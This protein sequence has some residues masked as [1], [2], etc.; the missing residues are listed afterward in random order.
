M[1]LTEV[2]SYNL[3]SQQIL[4]ESWDMLTESQR[5]HVGAWEKNVWPLMEQLNK[6][7]EA[8]LTADQIQQIFANAEKVSIEGGKN[9]TALGK[10]AK[11]T[12]EVSG[13]IKTEIEKLIKQAAD[14]EPVKNM[15]QQFDKL[16]TEIA[17]KIK[18]MQGGDKILAGVDKWKQFAQQNPAKSAF[19]IGAMTSLLAFASGGIMS[20]AAIGFFL[21]LANNTIQGDKL[22]TAVGKGIKTAAIGAIAGAI[23]DAVAAD[24]EVEK[25]EMQDGKIVGDSNVSASAGTEELATASNQSPEEVASSLAEMTVEEYKLAYA[26]EIAENYANMNG[27]MSDAMIQKIA[28][29]VEISGN[30]PENFKA[31]FDGTVVRGNIYLTPEEAA[32][33]DQFVNKDDPFAPNGVLGNETTEWMKEN[34]EGFKEQADAAAAEQAAADAE[35]KAR[36]DAMSPEEQKAFDDKRRDMEAMWGDPNDYTPPGTPKYKTESIEFIEERLWDEFE[37]YQQSLNEGPL[38][39]A[40]MN[41]AKSVGG[42]AAAGAKA[43]GGGIASAA[44][45]GAAAV[46]KELGQQITVRKLNA[47]WK[48]AGSPTD[49]GSIANILAQA[50]MD[51]AQIGLVSTNTKV[52][53][54]AAPTSTG[55]TAS[56]AAEPE[57]VDIKSLADEIKKAGPEVVTAVKTMLTAKPVAAQP[58]VAAKAKPKYKPAPKAAASPAPAV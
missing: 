13:K 34:V 32:K 58:K 43:V 23:G 38:G 15:D 41:F 49:T 26:K 44:K 21:R 47:L 50:G 9:M 39:T 11:V 28:D 37:L 2:T 12:A 29:N 18:T 40:A 6:L 31:N 24:I 33:W 36:Y 3:K 46:G 8:E 4:N 54:K 52:D 16:R 42:V 17:N 51:D 25:P 53:L 1:K 7:F 57:T 20:G 14:S 35:L 45:K 55:D 22:S 30:Y 27:G 10:G 56:T 48:K 5:M 19:I